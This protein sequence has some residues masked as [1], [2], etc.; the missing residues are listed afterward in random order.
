MRVII[1]ADSL[2]QFIIAV[3]LRTTVYKEAEADLLMYNSMPNA[4]KIYTNI[5]NTDLFDDCYI[6]MSD[7]AIGSA[8]LNV[9]RKILKGFRWVEMLVN[10][11][12]GVGK[13]IA[14]TKKKYD[15]FIY[16]ANGIFIDGLYNVCLSEN[17]DMIC[18]RYEG[19]LTSYIHDHENKKKKLRDFFET[20]IKI[21][22][23]RRDLAK[24]TKDYYFFEPELIQFP[25]SYNIIKLEKITSMKRELINVLN[26][27]FEFD[28]EKNK[29]AERYIAFEDGN[30][31]FMNDDSEVE[32]Y[33]QASKCLKEDLVVRLHPRRGK[34]RFGT[35]GIKSQ[36][37]MAPWEIYLLNQVVNK[38]TL[39]TVASGSVFTSLV[40]F[41]IDVK[42]ILLYKCVN[43]KIP[44]IN[45]EFEKL[46]KKLNEKYN[47]IKIPQNK[48][49]Y[50]KILAELPVHNKQNP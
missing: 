30:L 21:M 35:Y 50:Y 8:K 32:L 26:E 1:E 41:G 33:S 14:W 48:E 16:S 37:T 5:V 25:H 38:K 10:P 6:V 18:K 3:H 11:G 47:A 40:Y 13:D 27:I 34:N 44:L 24:D 28:A 29:I 49:E 45:P 31:Y 36:Q 7:L 20:N 17:P 46:I 15:I 39:L 23:G 19:S 9:K 2:I 12:R 42:V 43:T 4:M 22:F